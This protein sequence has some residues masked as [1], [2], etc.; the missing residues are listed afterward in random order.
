MAETF[1]YVARTDKTW[2]DIDEKLSPGKFIWRSV[3]V[4]AAHMLCGGIQASIGAMALESENTVSGLLRL[5]QREGVILSVLLKAR[6]NAAWSQNPDSSATSARGVLDSV[7]SDLARS[8]RS[9]IRY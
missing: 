3:P 1:R 2:I 8:R 6:V 5:R 4:L 7:R 9:R